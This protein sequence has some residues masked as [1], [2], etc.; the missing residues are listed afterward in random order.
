MLG[1]TQA[2][3]TKILEMTLFVV[4]GFLVSVVGSAI[5]SRFVQN[6]IIIILA[7]LLLPVVAGVMLFSGDKAVYVGAGGIIAVA[8]NLARNFLASRIDME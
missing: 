3:L 4:G 5:V 6:T 8:I 7:T 2:R 1:I